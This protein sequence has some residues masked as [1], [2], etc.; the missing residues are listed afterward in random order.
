M[1]THKIIL[2]HHGYGFTVTLLVREARYRHRWLVRTYRDGPSST[3]WYETARDS[4]AAWLD[5]ITRMEENAT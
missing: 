2:E 5:A 3:T 1:T 4:A